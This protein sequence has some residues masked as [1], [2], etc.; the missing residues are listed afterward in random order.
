[1][2]EE[3]LNFIITDLNERIGTNVNAINELSSQ[4]NE[5]YEQ[6]QSLYDHINKLTESKN[7]S[8]SKRFTDHINTLTTKV[9]ALS[10]ERNTERAVH[11]NMNG[12]IRNKDPNKASQGVN[13][14]LDHMQ[15]RKAK[16][17]A[18]EDERRAKVAEEERKKKEKAA[19][20]A[21]GIASG[22]IVDINK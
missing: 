17:K 19:R 8:P 12:E 10:S 9:N 15:A 13:D 3:Q 14:M 4:L 6:I 16:A 2:S 11:G 1:M 5:A 22:R 20:R 18:M 7:A 21:E